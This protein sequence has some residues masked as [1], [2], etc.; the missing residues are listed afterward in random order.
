MFHVWDNDQLTKHVSWL[1]TGAFTPTRDQ[2]GFN[3]FPHKQFTSEDFGFF[4]SAEKFKLS[5]KQHVSICRDACGHPFPLNNQLFFCSTAENVLFFYVLSELLIRI[6]WCFKQFYLM[7]EYLY[8]KY[9]HSHSVSLT[10]QLFTVSLKLWFCFQIYLFF[11]EQSVSSI[12][13]EF[14][15]I[16]FF[17]CHRS[18]ASPHARTFLFQ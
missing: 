5:T 15:R 4:L 3:P 16:L 14:P 6:C 18:K 11:I 1:A 7:I 8:A 13:Y 10:S 17:L 2:G 12:L 9:S